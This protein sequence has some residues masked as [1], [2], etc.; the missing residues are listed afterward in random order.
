MDVFLVWL[1]VVLVAD[2]LAC[3]SIWLGF[4]REV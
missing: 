2:L 4:G 1:A 3:A